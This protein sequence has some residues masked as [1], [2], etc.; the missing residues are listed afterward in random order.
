MRICKTLGYKKTEVQNNKS[1]ISFFLCIFVQQGLFS[2]I[3]NIYLEI[4]LQL[5]NRSINIE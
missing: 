3:P 2:I 1:Y 4:P 5:V